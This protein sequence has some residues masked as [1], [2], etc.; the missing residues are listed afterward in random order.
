M[1][2]FCLYFEIKKSDNGEKYENMS[3]DELGLCLWNACFE[4]RKEEVKKLILFGVD[5]E[6]IYFIFI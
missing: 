2:L 3:G 1:V 5:K 6:V 4:N